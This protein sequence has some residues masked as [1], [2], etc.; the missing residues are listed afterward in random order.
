MQKQRK[1]TFKKRTPHSRRL[2]CE[3]IQ[4][5]SAMSPANHYI[6]VKSSQNY[7]IEPYTMNMQISFFSIKYNT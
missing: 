5:K 2:R 3:S 1:L 4:L 6:Q 7:F